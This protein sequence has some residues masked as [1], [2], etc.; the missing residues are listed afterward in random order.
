M[1][2]S[3]FSD[4]YNLFRT[5]LVE[6]RKKKGLAQA[7]V[8]MRLGRPQSYVSK[9]ERGE[10][11]LDIVEFLEVAKAL[12]LEPYKILKELEDHCAKNNIE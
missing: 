7:D 6:A 11:R 8:A 12:G 10:R 3:I 5:R 1:S 4:T 2:K 9:Y